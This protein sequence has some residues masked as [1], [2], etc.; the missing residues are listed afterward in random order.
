[1]SKSVE[2]KVLANSATR[3]GKFKLRNLNSDYDGLREDQKELLR[4]SINRDWNTPEFKMKYFIGE[5][6]IT[7]YGKLKQYILELKSREDVCE[8][9]E[10][11][12]K[13]GLVELKILKRDIENEQ[14]DLKRELLEVDLEKRTKE[15]ARYE[16]KM[17][18]AYIERKKFLKLIDD[19]NNSD[20]GKLPDGR[21]LIEVLGDYDT[22]EQYEKEYWTARLAKQAALDISATGRI[23]AGNMDAISQLSLQQQSQVLYIASDYGNR[24]EKSMMLLKNQTD[25]NLRLALE[26][27]QEI[28]L[29][30]MLSIKTDSRLFEKV[31]ALG[32]K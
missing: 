29:E 9:M 2:E 30:D 20:E 18:D 24:L 13:R 26:N 15:L 28:P 27:K 16:R 12:Y 22:E 25:E 21:Y 31:P 10:Y 7:P 5:A 19:F 11:D 17:E 4:Y 23:S 6:Q 3:P 1:M 32:E 14:D 8:V